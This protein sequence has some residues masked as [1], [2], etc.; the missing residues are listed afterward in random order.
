MSPT[1]RKNRLAAEQ[2]VLEQD[3]HFGWAEQIYCLFREILRNRAGNT[4]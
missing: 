3:N 2:N 1:E 4:G